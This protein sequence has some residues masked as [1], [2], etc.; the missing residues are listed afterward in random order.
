MINILLIYVCNLTS[1]SLKMSIEIKQIDNPSDLEKAFAIRRQVFCVEQNVSE[2]I[3]MDEFDDVATH[4]LAYIDDNPV[5]TAR[6]RFTEE[7]AKLER[8][9]VLKDARGKGVG[10]EL[11]EYVVN[12]LQG[13]DCI[14]LNAQESVIKFYEKFGFEVVGNRFYEADIPHKKMIL[15]Q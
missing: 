12:K 5:G 3:E 2:E 10:E 13:N 4:I 15:K 1:I 7:G 9:A 6:W 11:V 8:F 14:Y